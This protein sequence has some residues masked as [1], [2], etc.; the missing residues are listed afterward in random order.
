MI[1]EILLVSV[2]QH[3]VVQQKELQRRSLIPG[4]ATRK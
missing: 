1:G 4:G 2:I 3:Y